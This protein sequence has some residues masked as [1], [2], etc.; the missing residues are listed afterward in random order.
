MT[1]DNLLALTRKAFGLSLF[2]LAGCAGLNTEPDRSPATSP[3]RHMEAP[4]AAVNS[5]IP[6]LTPSFSLMP[7]P[8]SHGETETYTLQ[9]NKVD[10]SELLFALA[11]ETHIDVDI[12]PEVSGQVT[13]NAHR[14]TLPRIVERIAHQLDLRHE[15]RGRHLRI[16]PD[17][18]FLKTYP[19]DYVTVQRE[20]T[21]SISVTTQVA[22]TGLPPNATPSGGA[23]SSAQQTT[24]GGNNNSTTRVENRSYNR[25]WD[26]LIGNIRDL[27]RETDK[28]L[29]EG[30]S[31]Q[32]TEHSSTHATSG[33]GQPASGKT[34][35]S[36][37]INLAYSSTPATLSNEGVTTVRRTTY[38]E[39]A[40]V[41]AH[42]ESGLITVRAT[43][44]QHEKIREYIDRV[45]AG[46]QRQVSIEATIAEVQLNEGFEQGIDWQKLQPDG[47]GLTFS[48]ASGPASGSGTVQIGFLHQASQLAASLKLL[49]K[50][51][52]VRVLSSPKLSVLNNQAAVLKVVD[53]RIYFTIK[54]DTTQNQDTSLTTYSTQVNSVPIGFVMNVVPQISEDNTVILNLRPSIS[55]IVGEIEDP[56]P[57]LKSAGIQ[58]TIPL[59]RTREMESVLRIHDGQIAVLGG[60]MEDSV[61]QD[62]A[63]LPGAGQ[64]PFLGRLF[65]QRKTSSTR[66]ELV[67]FIRPVLMSPERRLRQNALLDRKP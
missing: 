61:H 4:A 66:S 62:S 63:G 54:A 25:F 34:S 47:K 32:V 51:G 20:T 14:Q 64:V 65:Q 39:A 26:T 1:R 56:N 38:R 23:P 7:W 58:S 31:E 13:L 50:F 9:V 15:F 60:L 43:A 24:P 46:A 12:H 53:N 57:A 49:E 30:S 52:Q 55:R 17:K 8:D 67:I 19:V 2:S 21:G 10:V 16:F 59:I 37:P 22:S 41:I 45:L 28:L 5:R 29:P 44:R 27:L 48:Q 36:A 33:T 40:S 6:P 35:G 42:P 11:R 18:P 3:L